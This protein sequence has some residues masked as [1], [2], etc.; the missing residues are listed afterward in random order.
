[1]KLFKT[2]AAAMLLTAGLSGCATVASPAA[3]LLVTSVR[4]PITATD[5][6]DTSKQ[7]TSCASSILG[8]V[9]I[10]DASIEQAKRSGSIKAVASVS[11]DTFSVLGLYGRFCTI[12]TG[13]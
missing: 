12:V 8:L 6:V 7:G 9:A 10:G 1:M 3:G 11:Y 2:T 4:A 13:S 5:H